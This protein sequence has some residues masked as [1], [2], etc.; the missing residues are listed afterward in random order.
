MTLWICDWPYLRHYDCDFDS[1]TLLLFWLYHFLCGECD[2]V[3]LFLSLC[4]NVHVTLLWPCNSLTQCCDSFTLS[5]HCASVT[6][7]VCEYD[8]VTPFWL[9][10]YYF[11]TNHS[12]NVTLWPF[13]DFGS[14]SLTLLYSGYLVI[15]LS[16][17]LH[18][19]LGTSMV[20]CG[21][22]THLLCIRL[23]QTFNFCLY[24]VAGPLWNT[25]SCWR[26]PGTGR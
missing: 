9:Y 2:L 6:I 22:V 20:I 11:M 3:T 8:S 16:L 25:R 12:V 21:T 10:D 19:F 4:D 23:Y 13:W 1:V 24:S 18:C 17:L 26:F 14:V 15:W 7:R 5:L